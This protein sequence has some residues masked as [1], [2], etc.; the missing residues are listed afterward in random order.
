MKE[1]I[2]KIY[3]PRV[4]EMFLILFPII[5]AIT[6]IIKRNI[7]L[8]ISPGIIYKA[9]FTLYVLG[10]LLLIKK[11]DKKHILILLG[12]VL[13][14]CVANIAVVGINGTTISN[15]S[16]LLTFLISALFFYYY[17]KDGN[18]IDIKALI[19]STLIYCIL[20]KLAELTGTAQATYRG[21]LTLG[22]KGWFY[23]GNELSAILSI[24]LPITIM[25]AA[26]KIDYIAILTMLL[27]VHTLFSI[28]TK[29]SLVSTVL[30]IAV[31]FVLSIVWILKYKSK[32]SICLISLLV[33]MTLYT[34]Y[35]LPNTASYKFFL[36]RIEENSTTI[37]SDDD[38]MDYDITDVGSFILNGRQDF[39]KE[40]A[41]L[42]PNT[43]ITE[44]LFGIKNENKL[45]FAKNE[46][47]TIEID[48]YDILI[49][50]GIIGFMLFYIPIALCMISC[51]YIFVK[52]Q[53]KRKCESY[54]KA[55]FIISLCVAIAI[56]CI[57]GHVLTSSTI[58]IFIAYIIGALFSL[59]KNEN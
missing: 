24:T 39:L 5:E 54:E 45:G 4:I 48:I 40:Q 22:T 3:T 56:S 20:V 43:N 21:D 28:G 52:C 25:Y 36:V 37:S 12:V 11:D 32:T 1:K 38:E 6:S 15:I 33:V 50:Y 35:I 59:E 29:T 19:Y 8:F 34:L 7:D 44:K 31:L 2:S 58:E 55:M 10:Y 18:K 9:A 57:A 30:V 17:I 53:N 41:R 42:Y 26:K 14:F 51:A 49:N 13:L 23:S 46:I 47:K 27:Q 16:K